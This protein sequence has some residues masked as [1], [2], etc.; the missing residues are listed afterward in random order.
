MNESTNDQPW[1]W[2]SIVFFLVII[3]FVFGGGCGEDS[4]NSLFDTKEKCTF[5]YGEGE[6]DCSTCYG[7]G[8]KDCFWCNGQGKKLCTTC[9]GGGKHYRYDYGYDQNNGGKY[10]YYYAQ[11]PCNNCSQT[12]RVNCTN[13]SC[14][15]GEEDCNYCD[16]E[17]KKKC[18]YCEGEGYK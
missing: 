12:G 13:Y 11:F 14:E 7:K 5:C 2:E 17:G 16:G 1:S 18:I 6:R 3:Y 15:Y 8:K 4:G 10:H 9:G